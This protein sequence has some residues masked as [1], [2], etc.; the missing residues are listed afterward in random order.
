MKGNELDAYPEKLM[1]KDLYKLALDYSDG[2]M[3]TPSWQDPELIEYA[4]SKGLPIFGPV[5]LAKQ[6]INNEIIEFF[7]SL[8]E[9]EE[10]EDDF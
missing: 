8:V 2:L 7:E 3:L 5:D 1:M 9:G 10:P 6:D 4:R